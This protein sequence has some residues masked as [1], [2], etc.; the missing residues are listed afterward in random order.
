MD[1]KIKNV[2][3][4]I[5]EYK[6]ICKKYKYRIETDDYVFLTEGEYTHIDESKIECMKHNEISYIKYNINFPNAMLK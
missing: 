1:D 6:A 4:F 5:K 3:N 2:E